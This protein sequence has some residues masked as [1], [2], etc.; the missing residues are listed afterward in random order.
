MTT[1]FLILSFVALFIIAVTLIFAIRWKILAKMG[2]RNAIRRKVTMFLIIAGSLTGTAFIVGSFVINDSFQY[3]L[4]SGIRKNLGVIDEVVTP[5]KNTYFSTQEMTKM[6]DGL[7][8]SPYVNSVLPI[9]TKSTVAAPVGDLKSL[10]PNKIA[11][12]NFIGVDLNDLR[13]FGEGSLFPNITLSGNE[14]VI[15][16]VIAKALKLSVGDYFEALINPFQIIFGAPQKFKIA[17]IVNEAGVLGYKGTQGFVSPIFMSLSQMKN[18]FNLGSYN[19]IL[20]ANKGDYLSGAQY[21]KN[22]DDE[23][24]KIA[25]N[26]VKINNVKE[27][28]IASLNQ[29]QIAWL[30][31]ILSGFS[32]GAGVLLLINVYTMLS[33]ERMSDLGTLRAIGFSK[34]RV[35]F[36][37]YFEGFVY[38]LIASFAGVFVGL[39]IAWFMIEEF[40]NFAGNLRNQVTALVSTGSFD[41]S[42]HFSTIS[43]IY[44][45][46]VGL[47]I[48]SIVLLYMGFRVGRLNIVRAIRQI[49]GDV[50]AKSKNRFVSVLVIFSIFVLVSIVGISSSNAIVT[51]AGIMSTALIFPFFIEDKRLKRI[52]GNIFSFGIVVF[53]FASNLIPY[54]EAESNKSLWLLGLRSFSILLVALFLLYYNFEFFDRIFGFFSR[55][56]SRASVKLAIAETSQHKRRAGLT[57]AM[58]SIVI[59]VISL[60]TVIPYSQTLQIDS[61]EKSIFGGYDTVGIPIIGKINVTSAQLSNLDFLTYYATM[62]MVSV[63]YAS[64][65]KISNNYQM[66]ILNKKLVDGLD[67]KVKDGINGLTNL[68]SLWQYIENHPGTV[69]AFGLNNTKIGQQVELANGGESS[70]NF[71]QS[72]QNVTTASTLL[73]NPHNF[74]VAGILENTSNYD[75]IPYGFYTSQETASQLSTALQPTEFLLTKL[76][77]TNNDQKYSNF[78]KLTAFLKIRFIFALFAKQTVEIFTNILNGFVNIINTFLYFGLSVGIIGLAILI[79]KSLHERKRTVGILKALGFSQSMIFRSF[80]LEINFVVIVGIL[81]GFISGI[82]TSYLIYTT[83]NLGAVF[84][85]WTQFIELGI[86]FYGISILTTFFPTRNA[87]RIPPVEALRYRE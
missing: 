82:V 39:G 74:I 38:S 24:L 30:F 87:T 63:K 62:S 75:A 76:A 16:D 66:V 20:V 45:F 31:L 70:F 34:R 10:D 4:Y 11:Q 52:V 26:S 80:F 44:G 53:A 51:Y 68:K 65:G 7:S 25:G 56:S 6:L 60:M 8:S 71:S 17:G 59:F 27:D 28:Q 78:Q 36:I 40:S 5:N 77:G 13:K 41:F 19:E 85:P 79:V 61:A 49:P 14:V 64:N 43:L 9:I 3:F 72:S 42:L 33:D 15:S 58:Y 29:G 12:V 22:V 67:L 84:I 46:L 55:S 69:I 54:I 47:I 1:S 73:K 81:I 86:V 37:L 35:G 57:I 48:P 23:L 50:N 18:I 2:M 83:L 32:I 21:T